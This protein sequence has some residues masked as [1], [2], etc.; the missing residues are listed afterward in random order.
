MA[1]TPTPPVIP[2]IFP[3]NGGRRRT[4][5]EPRQFP[6]R[7]RHPVGRALIGYVPR[8]RPGSP[9]PITR[10]LDSALL[11]RRPVFVRDGGGHWPTPRERLTPGQRMLSV[12]QLL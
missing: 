5:S 7:P 12:A 4:L 1:V 2:T 6:Q 8:T 11:S 3:D 10:P 9:W